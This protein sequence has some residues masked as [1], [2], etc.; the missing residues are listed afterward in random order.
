M[1]EPAETAM[2]ML[3]ILQ[4]IEAKLRHSMRVAVALLAPLA[5]ALLLPERVAGAVAESMASISVEGIAGLAAA[6][7]ALALIP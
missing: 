4:R 5:P 3:R 1:P 7:N 2:F 6:T